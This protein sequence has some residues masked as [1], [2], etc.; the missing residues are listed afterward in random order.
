MKTKMIRSIFVW[1]FLSLCLNSSVFADDQAGAAAQANN[2][3]ANMTAFNIQDYYI[4]KLTQSD[5][6]ANQLWARY[7]KPFSVSGTNWLMRASL[8]M[9][10]YPTS[11]SG[12]Y[13]TG[14]GDSPG[15]QPRFPVW[16]LH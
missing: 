9:N 12:D 15:V 5:N 13:E 1:T 8:P 11:A 6:T 4:G 3:L 2:P 7:A 14:L 16:H 10:T